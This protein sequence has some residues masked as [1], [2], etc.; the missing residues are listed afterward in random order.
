MAK[1]NIPSINIPIQKDNGSIDWTWY[2]YL[3]W[4]SE[5][6]GGGNVRYDAEHKRAVFE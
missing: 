2:L 6:T 4:L 3:Q 5:K 1:Q